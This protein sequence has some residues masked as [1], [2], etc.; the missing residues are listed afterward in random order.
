MKAATK[1]DNEFYCNPK[2]VIA[3]KGN[4]KKQ[5]LICNKWEYIENHNEPYLN[6]NLGYE[7]IFDKATMK[8]IKRDWN[9]IGYEDETIGF[10]RAISSP[11]ALYRLI[12]MFQKMPTDKY[13][14]W[15][16]VVWSFPLKHKETGEILSFSEWKGGFGFWT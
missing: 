13:N 9:K 8:I 4:Y 14:D 3:R 2:Y 15:Y 10:Y 6:G 11:L 12:C 5:E 1:K 7:L 16:K